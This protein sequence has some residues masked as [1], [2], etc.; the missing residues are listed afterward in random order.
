MD[1]ADLARG[2][3]EKVRDILTTGEK[4]AI[5]DTPPRIVDEA[6]TILGI[7]PGPGAKPHE[8]TGRPPS[9]K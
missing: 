6:R 8:P 7:A 3:F 9:P 5:G 1:K 4:A 2:H